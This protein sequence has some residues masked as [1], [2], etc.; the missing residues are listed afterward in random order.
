MDKR[1]VWRR[2]NTTKIVAS[3]FNQDLTEETLAIK[4]L[5]KESHVDV[6]LI[7]EQVH[8]EVRQAFHLNLGSKLTQMR[9]AKAKDIRMST[10]DK[11]MNNNMSYCGEK[12]TIKDG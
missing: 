12:V 2:I 11:V 3:H 7:R 8:G 10:D 5:I 6:T 1:Y 4:K 9:D